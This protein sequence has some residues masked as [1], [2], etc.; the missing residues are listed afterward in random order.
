M[1]RNTFIGVLLTLAALGAAYGQ[2]SRATIIGRVMDSTGAAVPRA[3]I[4]AVNLATNV[5]GT[6]VTNDSGNFEVPYLLPGL[7]RVAVDKPG[8]KTAVRDQ[9]ELR[10][11]DRLALDFSLQ[12]GDV[13]ESI[14]VT[15]ETPLLE[16]TNA[17]VGMVMNERHGAG[18]AG[19]GREPVLS[20]AAVARRAF[21][22]R[23]WRRQPDG[24]GQRNRHDRQR[25][26]RTS[27]EASVD[28][29]PNMAQR[30]AVFSPPQDLV[31]EFK[32]HTAGYDASL[33]HAA[34]AMTNVSIKSGTNQFHG[35]AICSSRGGVPC[36]GSPTV[37]STIPTTGPIN[38]EKKARVIEDGATSAGERR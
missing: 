22:R 2:E 23:S 33:G 10:V 11:S 16:T 29:S 30:N 7:Y 25:D 31:Q 8:F 1:S 36:P 20:D 18:A 14:V 9:I 13:A 17:S 21:L 27:S 5:G 24:P 3:E 38:E 32:I 15:G 35:T 6:S 4:R 12:V 37:S 19:G 28:G 34:G 26:A